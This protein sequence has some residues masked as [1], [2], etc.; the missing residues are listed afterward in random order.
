MRRPGMSVLGMGVVAFFLLAAV[1]N[2]GSTKTATAAGTEGVW[3]GKVVLS[4]VVTGTQPSIRDC[5]GG[6]T[7]DRRWSATVDLNALPPKPTADDD[8]AVDAIASADVTIS[9]AQDDTGL[10]RVEDLPCRVEYSR[11]TASLRYAY[12]MVVFLEGTGRAMRLILDEL[13]FKTPDTHSYR[14]TKVVPECGAV[15]AH[16]EP[17]TNYFEPPRAIPLGGGSIRYSKTRIAGKWTFATH[18]ASPQPPVAGGDCVTDGFKSQTFTVT[19]DLRRISSPSSAAATSKAT[20]KPSSSAC[21]RNPRQPGCATVR[22]TTPTTTTKAQ[23]ETT[24]ETT[25]TGSPV[26]PKEPTTPGTVHWLTVLG[27][28]F[29]WENHKLIYMF[30]HGHDPAHPQWVDLRAFRDGHGGWKIM[31][32]SAAFVH[33]IPAGPNA[34]Q[35]AVDYLYAHMHR[36]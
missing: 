7:Y 30:I 34:D 29:K 19:V 18:C 24:P 15:P 9:Y 1:A 3:Q 4:G 33:R 12:R 28:D 31:F 27:M 10:P 22:S 20:S 6:W 16:T 21:A 32:N 35:Q 36:R 11:A 2:A 14:V 8:P 25:P 26:V 13:R 17:E 23:A 5:C